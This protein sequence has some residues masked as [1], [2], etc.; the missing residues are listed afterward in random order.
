MIGFT[1]K[2]SGVGKLGK[3]NRKTDEQLRGARS[4]PRDGHDGKADQRVLDDALNPV[5]M[6]HMAGPVGEHRQQ[7][8][9]V[10]DNATISSVKMIDPCGRAKELAPRRLPLRKCT[11]RCRPGC[12][13]TSV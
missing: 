3:S 4:L 11:A 2:F 5:A 13:S 7:L 8:I 9:V 6:R 1:L 12:S 10:R